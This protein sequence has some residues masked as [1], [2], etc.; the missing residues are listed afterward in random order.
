MKDRSATAPAT[1]YAA[2]APG[3]REF[4][5]GWL[6]LRDAE[7]LGTSWEGR[8]TAL[9]LYRGAIRLLARAALLRRSLRVDELDRSEMWAR[10][11]ELPA[12][13]ASIGALDGE[14]T[15][16]LGKMVTNEEGDLQ[17]AGL[18]DSERERALMGMRVLAR[19]LA[20]PLE[21]EAHRAR[22]VRRARWLR[23]TLAVLLGILA[24]AWFVPRWTV[25]PNLALHRPVVV[26]GSDPDFD[27]DPSRV[28]DG[29]KLNLGFHT[30][31]DPNTTVTIDLG[32][33][34]SIHRV[35]IY[36]RFDCCQDR[37]VPL[38]L[39]VSSDGSDYE[40]VARETKTFEQWSAS[41]PPKTKA[42]FVRLLHEKDDFF[43]L[44]EIEVY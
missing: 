34:E 12:W 17:L 3:F 4:E 21:E 15:G 44:A 42:R 18:S 29:D 20:A 33:V 26:S 11:R 6:A 31:T 32:S 5:L 8:D 13:S 16:W 7:Q 24:V 19:G 1:P 10:A 36:N 30:G 9:L 23:A 2:P 39:Q 35:E 43:H 41:L 27:I 37:A 14:V 25:R 38:A 22:R 28:V 40:T